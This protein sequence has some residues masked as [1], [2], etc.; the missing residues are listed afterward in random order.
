M[1]FGL[2]EGEIERLMIF[3]YGPSIFMA[4]YAKAHAPINVHPIPID[5]MMSHETLFHT[6]FHLQYSEDE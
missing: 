1:P 2:W 4:Y 3:F 6:F 5:L